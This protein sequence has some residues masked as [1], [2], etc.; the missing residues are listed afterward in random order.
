MKL[1]V[2]VLTV[3]FCDQRCCVAF[4]GENGSFSQDNTSIDVIFCEE[5]YL[6]GD[7]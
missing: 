7:Y 1:T 6:A 2:C 4:E 5:C 3:N